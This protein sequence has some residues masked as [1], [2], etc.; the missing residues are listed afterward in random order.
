M[1]ERPGQWNSIMVTWFWNLQFLQRCLGG[2][3]S[4]IALL[5]VLQD[6]VSCI[7]CATD[8]YSLW[9]CGVNDYDNMK[10]GVITIPLFP[11]PLIS[12]GHSCCKAYP[13][14]MNMRLVRAAWYRQLNFAK[15][16]VV[17]CTIQFAN[18]LNPVTTAVL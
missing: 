8:E 7:F 11:P 12:F 16:L 15:I 3:F 5:G 14:L 2:L 17:L 4:R 10:R 13:S 1:C 9:E 6:H 18:L